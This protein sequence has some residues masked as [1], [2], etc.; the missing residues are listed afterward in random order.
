MRKAIALFVMVVMLLGNGLSP[1]PTRAEGEV[2][3]DT[4]TV[5]V[6]SGITSYTLVAPKV[7]WYTGV[8]PCPPS[9][10]NPA[11]QAPAAYTETIKRIAS[12][13][14][15]VRTLY[16]EQKNCNQNAVV[17]NIVSDGS[18]LYWLGPTGLMRLS[19]DANPGDAPQLVNALV[20]PP[21]EVADGGDKIFVIHHN[22]G[23]SNTQ[24]SYVLKSN[25]QN[26]FL[27]TPGNYAGNLK[28]DGTYVYYVVAGNLIRQN[29]GVDGGI[30][31]AT[32]V[33]GYYPEG[34][35]LLLCT[36]NPIRCYYSN[37]VYI[38][39]GA[40]IY[41]YNNLNSSLG[42]SPIY[43]SVD[44][45]GLVYELTTDFG[46][47]FFYERR[48][49][50]CSPDPCFASYSYV[51]QRT[52]R[53]GG[54]ADALYTYGPTLFTGPSNLRTDG[55][56]LFWQQD[57]TV[58]RLPNDA[59][60]LPQV[61]MYI[62][63]IEV[64]QSIQD[65]NNSV[66]LIK[67]K[68][69]FVRVYVKSA[70][71]AVAGVTAQL[72]A[73]ALGGSALL[74]VN[75]AGTHI[76]VR[77]NPDRNDINQSF[78]FE[79]PW[80]WTQQ[81]SL[82]MRVDLN[83]YKVPLEPNYGD[84]TSSISV[85]FQDSPSLSVEF[86]RLNYT[87][88]GT[89]Y[90]PRITNDVL[91]TYSWILRAY[92]L[93]G[94]V[95]QSFKPRLWDVDGGTQL[96]GLVNTS[97]PICKLIYSNPD[98]DISLCASYVT[99]GWLFYYRV[100]TQFGLL[101]V[102]LKTNAFY[103]GMISDASGNFPRGQAMYSQT[104]V[105]PAGTPGSPFGLGSGWDTDGTYADWYA[106]H[107]IG[108][109][110][111]RAHP[112]AGSDDPA[113]K[114][115]ENCGH[116]RSDPNFPYGNTSTAR[117]PIGPANN[118]MEGFDVGDPGFGIPAKVLPS[119]TWNDV[120]S[121]CSNQWLSDYTYKA[122]YNYMIAHPSMAVHSPVVTGDFLAITGV[123]NPTANT[124]GISFIRRMSDAVNVPPLIPGDYSI[125]LLDG[126]NNTLA[127]YAF[128]AQ[129]ENEAPTLSFGQ[130]VSF[131]TGTRKVEIIKLAD[132]SVLASQA[133]SAN[134]PVIS[135]V[136][137]QGAPDPVSGV[138]TLG[139]TASDPDGDPLSFD[140]AYSRDNGTTFQPV[141]SNLSGGSTKIDTAQLGGSG[142]AILRVTVS[143]GVN[144]A[145]A[146]SAPFVMANKPPQP[147]ILT[148]A[149]NTH[150][151]YGQLVNF[152]GMALDAQDGT[153][154]D[155]GLVWKDQ[156]NN[157]LG[158]GAVLSLDSL[159]VGSNAISLQAT[160]S[161]GQSA[162][163][164]VTVIVDDDLNLPGPTLTTGPDQLGW[165]VGE[166][167]T[168]VQ[169]AAIS[170]GNAGSGTLNWTASSSAPWLTLD[171]ASGGVDTGD[172]SILTASADPS[173]LAGGTIYSANITIYVAA[174]GS[175]PAQKAV[176]PVSLSVGDVR[177]VP[178]GHFSGISLFLPLLQR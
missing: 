149:D 60:A 33:S 12:Y 177:S 143:D 17:S 21:G 129:Q 88:N 134:P 87:I 158:S 155:S 92:P 170:I 116:S 152:N 59:T 131:T 124:A 83:P 109:S 78:L 6:S 132:D 159:P 51:L 99:N 66:L 178:P 73:P 125:R 76:T 93:G 16:S 127:D 14:S 130:V 58:Q 1:A 18:Y 23:G 19:T 46:H 36:I 40:S 64:T 77:T 126:S 135:N 138:V 10:V 94:T 103:Y 162:S 39:K 106:A 141:A 150:V 145:F 156:N 173:G 43:T 52:A 115:V 63:G 147:Y 161:V 107:E 97:N 146:D 164:S 96:G 102:G 172:P 112:N 11:S 91:K 117:A 154:G 41:V 140:V 62:T 53:S 71:T 35:R 137:L 89:T 171:A 61:N 166:G 20:T 75:P 67:N 56:F 86:F 32:G 65:L 8:P 142:T 174:S 48:T 9:E 144:S 4:P 22:T 5:M 27:A 82:S 24:V 168:Q 3:N 128:S 38:G 133:V 139:W 101:N 136:A 167:S 44:N 74:P 148:P 113:T 2:V 57:D 85:N 45:T 50:P 54:A 34:L 13:G 175:T 119:S 157:T 108:H 70:G 104:S 80:S 105:G 37:S 98:D 79:L 111:G 163:A 31:L 49:I 47:L 26:V 169:S 84:N 81:S 120:M 7:F 110:L 72:S 68:R 90:S 176:I 114:A 123:I 118:S 153:V 28:F 15:P 122:M 151:H 42:A 121:Y 55:T 95:G 25:N 29:P 165:Q 30:T 100:A 69:T 160:N